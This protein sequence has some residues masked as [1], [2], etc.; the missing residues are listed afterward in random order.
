MEYKTS[1]EA[2]VGKQDVVIT[3]T[4]D[5][6]V[7]LLFRAFSDPELLG[8]WMHTQ[9][10]K[11]DAFTHGS[12]QLQTANQQGDILFSANGVFHQWIPGKKIV[13]T[14]EMENTPFG[15]QL[16]FLEF[17]KVSDTSSRLN[18]HVIYRSEADRDQV[19]HIGIG[20]EKGINIAHNK[21]EEITGKLK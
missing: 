5:L 1:V 15:T 12:Y 4:F 17:E 11:L 6:P 14:F 7:E 3:R 19:L 16:E 2:A 18:M 10:Q 13:R 21:L 9:V 8:K 20:L